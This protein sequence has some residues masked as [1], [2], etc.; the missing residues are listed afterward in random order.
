MVFKID[1]LKV[2]TKYTLCRVNDD[3]YNILP[4]KYAGFN[5]ARNNTNRFIDYA[6][7]SSNLKSVTATT[8]ANGTLYI[9]FYMS[10][11]TQLAQYIEL[12]NNCWVIEGESFVEKEQQAFTFPLGNEKLMIGDYL[13][14][15]GIHHVRGQVV[16]DGT[17]N[18]SASVRDNISNFWIYNENIQN[19]KL[20]AHS[21]KCNNFVYSSLIYSSA[22]INSL[23][24]NRTKPMFIFKTNVSNTIEEWITWLSTHNTTV[25][26]ELEEEVIVPYTSAQQEVYNQIKQALSYE[27]QTNISGTS[28]GSNPIFSVEGYQSTK[29]VLQDFATAIVALGGV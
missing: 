21:K 23:C 2:N 28:D 16:F 15:D 8:N 27:E 4:A 14:D 24:E 22:P 12:I 11:A 6:T 7:Q 20:K 13:A 25:E 29:L 3:G 1:G 19:A 9:V 26:Y 10:N 18:W 17:E 5:P